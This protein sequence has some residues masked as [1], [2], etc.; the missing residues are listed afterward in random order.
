MSNLFSKGIS[1]KCGSTRNQ[2]PSLKGRVFWL[3]FE[4]EGQRL[5][6]LQRLEEVKSRTDRDDRN[7]IALEKLE[8]DGT[9]ELNENHSRT[10][11]GCSLSRSNKL[12]QTKVSRKLFGK[13][14]V[15]DEIRTRTEQQY[16]Q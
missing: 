14:P 4:K 9:H 13:K 11:S 15:L 16:P 2:K 6:S 1:R 3:K 8:I 7:P 10:N 5:I 12:K